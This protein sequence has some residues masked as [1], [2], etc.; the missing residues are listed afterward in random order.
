MIEYLVDQITSV[1]NEQMGITKT[2]NTLGKK[3]EFWDLA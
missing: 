1:K 3:V 2:G